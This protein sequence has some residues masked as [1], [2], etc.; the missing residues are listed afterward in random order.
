FVEIYDNIVYNSTR[1]GAFELQATPSIRELSTFKP[2]NAKVYNN[3][4][5]KLNTGTPKF[6]EGRLLD[7]Y[8]TDGT[9]E[10]FNNLSFNNR[11]E[12]LINKMSG[13]NTKIIK[14]ENNKYYWNSN[15]AVF[16]LNTFKSKISGIGAFQ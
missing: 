14:N 12:H 6:F 3:T 15:E 1:Y 10:I 2:A 11:D 4:V 16:D 9:V 7:L 8:N 13:P 5:G